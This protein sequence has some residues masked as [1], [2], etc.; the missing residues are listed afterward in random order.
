MRFAGPRAR[1]GALE[2]ANGLLH[3]NGG[4]QY[5]TH[6]IGPGRALEYLLTVND[7]DAKTAE[8]Y[9]WVNRAYGSAAELA[10]EVDAI[11]ARIALWPAAALNA[12]K[13]SVRENDPAQAGLDRDL[14]RFEGLIGTKDTQDAIARFLTLSGG[15]TQG[16]FELGVDES[17]DVLL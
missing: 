17:W 16:W 3:G 9:G 8:Q 13:A 5:L 14:A 10:R 15:Q 2:V 11:A 1:L 4:A 6:L 7:V 12:T